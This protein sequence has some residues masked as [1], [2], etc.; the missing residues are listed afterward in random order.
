MGI[1]NRN[2]V[3]T[4]LQKHSIIEWGSRK[5]RRVARSSSSA[6]VQAA[7]DAESELA[8]FRYAFSELLTGKHQSRDF[9]EIA[10]NIPAHVITDARALY[11]AIHRQLS[12]CLGMEERRT[13]IEMQVLKQ[14][15]ASGSVKLKWVHSHAMVE[16]GLTKSD[17]GPFMLLRTFLVRSQWGLVLDERFLSAKKRAILGIDIFEDS[18]QDDRQHIEQYHKQQDLKYGYDPR[19]LIHNRVLGMSL[20]I[21]RALRTHNLAYVTSVSTSTSSSTSAPRGQ[22]L[23]RRS[24][25]APVHLVHQSPHRNAYG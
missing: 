11:D 9:D 12:S 13:G 8:V 23:R 7:N 17:R 18:R 25:R 15:M 2:G 1:T 21:R 24:D 20:P 4:E 3:E 16:N 10:K 22:A 14:N 19:F 6:E 5:L